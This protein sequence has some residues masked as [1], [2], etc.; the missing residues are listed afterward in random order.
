MARVHAA[1]RGVDW[2]VAVAK[3]ANAANAG[4]SGRGESYFFYCSPLCSRLAKGAARYEQKR[5][6]KVLPVVL[7]DARRGAAPANVPPTPRT[8][9]WG[10]TS[11]KEG[12]TQD[13]EL[14]GTKK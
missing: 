1:D 9:A 5:R 14:R 7:Y 4:R 6:R 12:R 11:T 8:A 13:M 2:I 10:G 3:A